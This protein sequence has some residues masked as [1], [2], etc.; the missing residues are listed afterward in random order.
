MIATDQRD[1]ITLI[2]LARPEQRNAMIPAMLEALI[3]AFVETA[4]RTS[5][6]VILTGSGG[7]FC[8]GAD[9]NWL[10]SFADPAD[11]VR[12]LVQLHHKAILA[13]H[14]LPVPLI[15]A[16]NG[17]AAEGGLS[18]ALAADYAVAAEGASFTAAYFRLGLTPDGGNSV[19]LTQTIGA[20]RTRELLLTNRRLSAAEALAWGMLNE[21]V[22]DDTLL[23]H[24]VAF[25]KGLGPVPP[26]TLIRT[27]ALLNAD[28][29]S[30]LEQ[31][32][33]AICSAARGEFF[34]QA[35]ARFRDA[36]PQVAL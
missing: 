3:D 28:F 36:H 7:S 19:L 11:G 25:A 22:P 6:P 5:R 21:V 32:A 31:E 26:E 33:E 1:G 12:E 29:V 15:A 30:R 13:M 16:V 9:L 2:R 34:Q 23:D 8:A 20:P 27:R 14:A 4:K 24:A 17:S 35:I 18:F 10:A